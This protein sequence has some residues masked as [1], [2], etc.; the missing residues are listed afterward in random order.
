MSEQPL[1]RSSSLPTAQAL[2]LFHHNWRW[3]PSKCEAPLKQC[4]VPALTNMRRLLRFWVQP[5]QE[6]CTKSRSTPSKHDQIP[7]S[8]HQLRLQTANGG[9]APLQFHDGRRK[10]GWKHQQLSLSLIKADK[11]PSILYVD[12]QINRGLCR[13]LSRVWTQHMSDGWRCAHTEGP[14]SGG[15]WEN[16]ETKA[17]TIPNAK[18]TQNEINRRRIAGLNLQEWAGFPQSGR[19]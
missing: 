4:S 3:H 16:E 15:R 1:S 18:W 12:T 8:I 10:L 19:Q 5:D 6:R 7:N 11:G 9:K 14:T 2:G 13:R 17:H